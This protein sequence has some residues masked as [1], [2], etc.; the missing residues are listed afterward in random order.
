M[1]CSPAIFAILLAVS[2]QSVGSASSP[3][4][5]GAFHTGEHRNLFSELLDKD[6]KE[7]DARLE[8]TW[9]QLFYGDDEKERVYYPAGSDLAYVED[10]GNGDVRSEGMS[11]GMMIAVQ[12]DKKEEFDRLWKWART[13]MYHDEGPHRGLFAWHCS[14]AGVRLDE[15][16]A[17]DGEVWMVTALFFAAG[18]WGNGEGIF[19]YGA[20]ARALLRTMLHKSEER[21]DLVTD[22]FD[23]NNRLVVFVPETGLASS[24]TDPSYHVPH[25]YELWARWADQDQEFWAAAAGASRAFL[26]SAAHPRTGLMPDYSHFDGSPI[27]PWEGGHDA[28]RFDAWRVGMNVAV[29][30]AWFAA[31]PWQVDQSNRW[32]TFFSSQGLDTYVNQYDLDGTP[33]SEDRSVGLVAMNAVAALGATID[34]APAFVEALW[35]SELPT[36]KW[37]YYDGMLYMLAMLHVSGE[38]QIYPPPV[39]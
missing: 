30:H 18:R 21:Q 32:L 35:K 11:Y 3:A 6:Q 7:I 16:A 5:S 38:F 9:Q 15:N 12:L 24:F 4:R 36:G 26:R 10:I 27:D 17:S 14:P 8:E 37:R 23:S 20:E 13:H 1:R 39:D 29:D 28:F 22:M 2:A 33:L 34:E 19:D 25:F 31:D